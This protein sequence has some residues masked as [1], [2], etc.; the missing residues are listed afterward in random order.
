MECIL[1]QPPS[2]K[3]TCIMENSQWRG[4]PIM[5][6]ILA[7]ISNFELSERDM[8]PPPTNEIQGSTSCKGFVAGKFSTSPITHL[9]D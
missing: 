3:K 2:H 8:P 4:V 9:E 6:G 1:V 5:V 7:E